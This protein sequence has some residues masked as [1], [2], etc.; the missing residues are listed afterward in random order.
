MLIPSHLR[1]SRR[2]LTSGSD[3]MINLEALSFGILLKKVA[4][5][6]FEKEGAIVLVRLAISSPV[7]NGADAGGYKKTKDSREGAVLV[8]F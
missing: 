2:M 8:W 4:P 6:F 1:I 5:S 3:L 7:G